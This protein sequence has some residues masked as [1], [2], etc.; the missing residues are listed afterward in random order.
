MHEILE[1]D[2][3]MWITHFCPEE[4][5]EI[6]FATSAQSWQFPRFLARTFRPVVFRWFPRKETLSSTQKS[7]ENECV[8]VAC[9]GASADCNGEGANDL[10]GI[11]IWEGSPAF[12]TQIHP[13]HHT[14]AS[15]PSRAIIGRRAKIIIIWWTLSL[16]VFAYCEQFRVGNLRALQ[17]G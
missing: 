3:S 10:P 9:L 4:M 13:V 14:A 6:S 16:S 2:I 11:T 1:S 12:I 15:T 17:S 8:N 5:S 7:V